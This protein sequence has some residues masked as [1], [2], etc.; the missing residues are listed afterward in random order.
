MQADDLINR[1][2][3]GRTDAILDLC[4]LENWQSLVER[5]AVTLWQ[6]LVYFNDVTGLRFLAE[7]YGSLGSMHVTGELANAA[8]FGHWQMCRYLIDLGA[9]VTAADPVSGETALHGGIGFSGGLEGQ[10]LQ[11]KFFW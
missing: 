2:S 11:A 1:I 5:D 6:W 7:R 4:T 3:K 10:P 9:D 8:F